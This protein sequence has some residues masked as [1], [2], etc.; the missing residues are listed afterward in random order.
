MPLV[1]LGNRRP[2]SMGRTSRFSAKWLHDEI[3]HLAVGGSVYGRNM[4]KYEVN[5]MDN[6]VYASWLASDILPTMSVDDGPEVSKWQ[7]VLHWEL[8]LI[9]SLEIVDDVVI[10]NVAD[11]FDIAPWMRGFA[12]LDL[13]SFLENP[14]VDVDRRL[15]RFMFFKEWAFMQWAHA[16]DGRQQESSPAEPRE[17]A[18][19]A[20][21]VGAEPEVITVGS[22]VCIR[23]LD[24]HS[25]TAMRGL[26]KGMRGIVV[27]A[28]GDRWQVKFANRAEAVCFQGASLSL[29]KGVP[30][31]DVCHV[32][33]EHGTLRCTGCKVVLYC[34]P[35]CQQADWAAH[36]AFCKAVQGGG[37]LN[38]GF[39]LRARANQ[40]S[41]SRSTGSLP[42]LVDSC[43]VDSRL[44]VEQEVKLC[45]ARKMQRLGAGVSLSEQVLAGQDRRA[46]L[47]TAKACRH[48]AELFFRQD[49][50][51]SD[52]EL[53]HII[54][55][56]S[57]CKDIS[58]RLR[59]VVKDVEA[60]LLPGAVASLRAAICLRFADFA[61]AE[62][63]ASVAVS[64]LGSVRV[65]VRS[66]AR[67]AEVNLLLAE[68]FIRQGLALKSLDREADAAK[69]VVL[70]LS[71]SPDVHL[72]GLELLLPLVGSTAVEASSEMGQ[73]DRCLELVERQQM[74]IHRRKSC[75]ERDIKCPECMVGL[76][77]SMM[78][79]SRNL[80]RLQSLA[81]CAT[82]FLGGRW[83]AEASVGCVS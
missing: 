17:S 72:P 26:Q 24:E 42:S 1:M 29:A 32:C 65:A 23:Q 52:P 4:V 6:R 8:L 74:K 49:V 61:E 73:C 11:G 12:E 58:S 19:D 80:A 41:K 10:F 71:R 36:E 3:L 31:H 82:W 25:S 47:E 56:V 62:R 46:L 76:R 59:G 66:P 53:P 67:R 83:I 28:Q 38:M 44:L 50:T 16:M 78:I 63:E 69:A 9:S 34:G 27:A 51:E 2:L 18:D 81:R 64:H 14:G 77:I 37:T 79:I 68:A 43:S 55:K 33:G 45:E 13:E 21:D 40:S 15:A 5:E 39:E 22:H 70:A 20:F 54:D 7:V 57:T 35:A 30:H 48:A 60:C 75:T